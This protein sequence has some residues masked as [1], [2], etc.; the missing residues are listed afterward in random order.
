MPAGDIS[1]RPCQRPVVHRP[2]QPARPARRC[3][4]PS[5]LRNAKRTTTAA[6]ANDTGTRSGRGLPD[7][8]LPRAAPPRPITLGQPGHRRRLE[9][10]PDRPPQPPALPRTRA[11]QPRGQQRVPAQVEEVVVHAHALARPAVRRTARTASPP[12]RARR[13]SPRQPRCRLRQRPPVQL[14]V[15]RQRQPV[16]H[17]ERR[18]DHVLRQARGQMRPQRPAIQLPPPPHHIP[19]QPPV[20]RP[21]PRT[22]TAACATTGCASS[23]ASISPGSIRNPRTFTCSSARPRNSSSPSG[24]PPRQVPGP[25]QPLPAPPNG[26]PRTAPPSARPGPS[27]PA[28][29][30]RR[31]RT[32]PPPPPPA[33]AATAIQHDTPRVFG[34]RPADRH[35]LPATPARPNDGTS[36]ATVVSVMPYMLIRRGPPSPLRSLQSAAARS[37]APHRRR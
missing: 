5:A 36:R 27:T 2:T 31:P 33:P 11:D 23:A 24:A 8:C 4:S 15:R 6:A 37:S 12:R 16:Q 13:P 1:Q 19:H 25:V 20:T 3:T 28:P 21:S 9:Q 17:H 35:R 26:Q 32:V 18:G 10:L 14:P 7:Q 22:T 29:A 34:H 30:R